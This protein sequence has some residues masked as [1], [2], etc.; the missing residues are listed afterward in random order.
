[1]LH[2]ETKEL[3]EEFEE[4]EAEIYNLNNVED[5]TFVLGGYAGLYLAMNMRNKPTEYSREEVDED[6][7]EELLNLDME[8]GTSVSH[9]FVVAALT[10]H[11]DLLTSALWD[12]CRFLVP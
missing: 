11:L 10:V 1:M 12:K 8:R 3:F 4:L 9:F 2:G 6:L 5:T 7:F